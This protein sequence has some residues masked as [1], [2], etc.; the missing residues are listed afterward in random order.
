MH[1][2]RSLDVPA[3]PLNLLHP[4]VLFELLEVVG[5]SGPILSIRWHLIQV[6]DERAPS[7]VLVRDARHLV[8]LVADGLALA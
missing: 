1:R 3:L 7:V 5:V 8:E 4:K 2:I 6:L